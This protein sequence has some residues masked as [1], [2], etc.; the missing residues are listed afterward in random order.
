MPRRAALIATT[1]SVIVLA[2]TAL[3][4]VASARPPGH[5]K[6]AAVKTYIVKT[7]TSS[8][9]KGLAVD[10]DAAGGQIKNRYQRVYPGFSAKLTADQARALKRDPDVASII[11]D[12]VVHS[13]TTQTNPTWGLDRIDQRPTVGDD[14][15]RFVSTG[16]AESDEGDARDE[17]DESDDTTAR[18][19]GATPVDQWPPSSW[20]SSS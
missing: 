11:A 18:T 9:A 3:A 8:A 17:S 16:A 14:E 2:A 12:S 5:P 6:D 7:R 15:Y 13:T 19:G 10:V 1:V 20:P 4:P